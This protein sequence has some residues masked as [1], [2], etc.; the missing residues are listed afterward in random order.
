MGIMIRGECRSCGRT[1]PLPD[2]INLWCGMCQKDPARRDRVAK[3]DI[4]LCCAWI[5]VMVVVPL[6]IAYIL[7]SKL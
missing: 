4:I 6:V 5:I 3:T 1:S 2:Q 7:R